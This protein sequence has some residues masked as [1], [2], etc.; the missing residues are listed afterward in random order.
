MV[1]RKGD[2]LPYFSLL[3]QKN[4]LRKNEDYSGKWLVLYTYPQDDTPGCTLEGIGFSSRQKE[5]ERVNAKVV[6]LS[7]D[8][9]ASHD[10]FCQKHSLS[11]ELLADP[12]GKLLKDLGVEQKEWHGKMYWDRVTFIADEKGIVRHIFENVNPKGHEDEVL[13]KLKHLQE[14]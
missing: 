13:R 14:E 8:D 1:L 3:N 4:S 5:F 12:Q 6:G 11:I 9:V 7:S 2:Y 10:R